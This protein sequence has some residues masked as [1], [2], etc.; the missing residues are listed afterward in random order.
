MP[1]A[2]V[3]KSFKDKRKNAGISR[4]FAQKQAA[5]KRKKK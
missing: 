1:K 2:K 3:S 5:K 4:T